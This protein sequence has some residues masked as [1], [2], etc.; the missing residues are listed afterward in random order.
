MVYRHRYGRVGGFASAA[1]KLI[2]SRPVKRRGR[3]RKWIDVPTPALSNAVKRV[4]NRQE[5][6]KFYS[7]DPADVDMGARRWYVMQP[8]ANIAKGT[9]DNQ[10]VGSEIKNLYMKMAFTWMAKGNDSVGSTRLATGVPLRVVVVRTARDLTVGKTAFAQISTT[11]R[12]TSAE[13]P[14]FFNPV[15][16]VTAMADPKSDV[17]VV[18]Q[19]YL[20]STQSTTNLIGGTTSFKIDGIKIPTYKFADETTTPNGRSMNYYVLITSSSPILPDNASAGICQ[21]QFHLYYKDA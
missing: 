6:T 8:I 7:V 13:L 18:K 14:L 17:K 3:P 5:E 21:A 15:Q 10:R 4:I 12:S 16:T 11:A 1:K 9:A 19:F 2:A 20:N